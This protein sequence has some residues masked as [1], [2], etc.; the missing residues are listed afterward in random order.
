MILFG[1]AARVALRIARP[2]SIM[3][4]FNWDWGEEEG[5]DGSFV[6]SSIRSCR[7]QTKSA[8]CG[9]VNHKIAG[10]LKPHI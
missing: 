5:G 6:V 7:L 9:H 8:G 10:L 1:A 2:E 4:V 3:S